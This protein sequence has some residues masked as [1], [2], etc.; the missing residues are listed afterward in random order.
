MS[1]I[2]KR[3]FAV[4]VA[5]ALTI[6]LLPGLRVIAADEVASGTCGPDL[7]WSLDSEGL[8]TI[9][10]EGEMDDW[11]YAKA[12]QMVKTPWDDAVQSITSVT[13][14]DGVTSIGRFAFYNCKNL[15]TI[16]ISD[17]ITTIGDYA[18]IGCSNLETILIPDGVTSIG[19]GAFL[20][21][22]TLR[23]IA[24]P[25]SVK[26]ID[27]DAFH[28]C[29]SLKS[30]VLSDSLTSIQQN[31]FSDC[32]SLETITIP[33]GVTSIDSEAFANCT[34]LKSI[35]IPDSVTEISDEAF[36]NCT[37][38]ETV[39]I[40][41]NVTSI[42]DYAFSGCTS[43]ESITI[44][45]SVTKIGRSAFSGCKSLRSVDLP[46]GLTAIQNNTFSGCTSIETVL[47]PDSV[48][49]INDLAFENCMSLKTVTI[50][51][52]TSSLGDRV[53]SKCTSLETIVI[54]N[55]V[56]WVGSAP[57]FGCT[58]L[59]TAVISEN[60][61]L[62][63]HIYSN[64]FKNLKTIVVS[65]ED[66]SS[67]FSKLAYSHTPA[68]YF[69]YDA[70]YIST[71]N[72]EI[73][74]KARSYCGDELTI[75]PKT[76]Y[77]VDQVTYKDANG[78]EGTIDSDADGRYFMPDSDSA[79]EVTVSFKH[80]TADVRFLSEDGK[81]ELQST[82]YDVN[83]VPS[84]EG[85]EPSKEPDAQYAYTFAGWT[86]GTNTYG[87]DEDLPVVTGDV[88]FKAVFESTTN[89]YTIEFVDEDGK[90]LQ[91]E[92]L[93]YGTTPSYKGT[94]PVKSEDD[95]YTYEFSGWSSE[96]SSVTGDATYK[97]V[98][99][100]TEK[101][102]P[103]NTPIKKDDTPTPVNTPGTYYLKSMV[104]QDG[105]II[106]TIKQS[107]DDTKT[108]DLLGTVS[109]DGTKLTEGDQYT[110][111]KGSAIIT[112]K[113]SYLDTLTTGNHKLTVT[114]TDGGTITVTY[115]VK[116]PAPESKPAETKAAA[117]STGEILA[118]TSVAGAVMLVISCGIVIAVVMRRR[119]D[120]INDQQ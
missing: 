44:P 64:E 103:T 20:S 116:A 34:N 6:N 119:R 19:F 27:C 37:T 78:K 71:G 99:T 83:V 87:P 13:I 39:L 61:L 84:Y 60:I 45:N 70:T 11:E 30:V 56:T 26:S 22:E 23:T 77:E 58:S 12:I 85:A 86:D 49:S 47:V 2:Y 96:I 108:Y 36:M 41:D 55:S 28:E 52:G 65:E 114:F 54:P 76:Y 100:S 107:E 90:V 97:A 66:Y 50:S 43:L 63:D 8:L 73:T 109:S 113:K 110:S 105:N 93:E 62:I 4:L 67:Y 40:P 101:S 82:T 98:F 42:G 118:V 111:E 53:F 29:K 120:K 18:F 75:T 88:D 104:E 38:L 92:S 32:S 14:E 80:I 33:N 17:S 79:L 115:E 68:V 89:K 9:S 102:E 72:G 1:K 91:S 15:E 81:T 57:F 16:T 112:V 117:A 21:C 35:S 51:D 59:E 31:T 5:F 74:G 3:I 24:L 48:T 46:D 106:F 95:K 94:T 10:G 69:Y 7:T 25:N